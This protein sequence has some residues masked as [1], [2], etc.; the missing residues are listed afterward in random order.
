MELQMI[1]LGH[2][3]CSHTPYTTQ[4]SDDWLQLP[5]CTCSLPEQKDFV[6]VEVL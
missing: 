5:H 2:S 1:A 3:S 6:L 4:G